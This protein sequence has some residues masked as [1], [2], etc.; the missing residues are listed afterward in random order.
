MFSL[1]LFQIHC[2]PGEVDAL[3]GMKTM[4]VFPIVVVKSKNPYTVCVIWESGD[5]TCDATGSGFSYI[6]SGL[7]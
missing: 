7:T 6:K 1:S 2:L 5:T 4:T 3:C